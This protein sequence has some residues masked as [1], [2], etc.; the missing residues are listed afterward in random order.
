MSGWDTPSRPTWDPQDGPEDSTQAFPDPDGPGADDRWSQPAPAPAGAG[1]VRTAARTSAAAISVPLTMAASTRPASVAAAAPISVPLNTTAATAASPPSRPSRTSSPRNSSSASPARPWPPRP[2]RPRP[3][4]PRPA[5]PRPRRPRPPEP[6][7][8]RVG[9]AGLGAG[10]AA[11]AGPRAPGALAPGVRPSGLRPPSRERA[12]GAGPTTAAWI[13]AG[14]TSTARPGPGQDFPRRDPGRSEFSAYSTYSGQPE[15]AEQAP[16][17]A[18][19]ADAELAAR[20]DP[21]LQDFFAPTKPDPRYAGGRPS[22]AAL[23]PGLP[24][25]GQSGP[26]QP[27]PRQSGPI[28]RTRDRRRHAEMTELTEVTD[29]APGGPAARP[30]PGIT[31]PATQPEGSPQL[32]R[33]GG[34]GGRRRTPR[35]GDE[36]SGSRRKLIIA[37]GAVVV[38]VIAV[39]G[40]LRARSRAVTR[41]PPPRAAPRRPHRPRPRPRRPGGEPKTTSGAKQGGHRRG[42]RDLGRRLRA[43]RPVHG[44][45]ATRSGLTRTSWRPPPRP[46]RPSS[47]PRS[48][49]A[50]ARSPAA[51]S[52][53]PTR[54]RTSRRSSSSA[55]RAPSTRRR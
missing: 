50:A 44:G 12:A 49:A 31:R 43:V 26:G 52:R 54:C 55:T 6:G 36:P 20:M 16:P 33:P 27:G 11:V 25:P 3:A 34:P 53:R 46:R 17:P 24:G 21:A 10:R 4:R 1:P 37:V 40:Y 15:Q 9:A 18:N 13:S 51:R 2:S 41:A 45:A 19:Q 47:S 7:R 42:Q 8:L 28:G 35:L 29:A 39:G 22:R 23:P 14:S 38:I 5:R 30:P 32:R 48:T